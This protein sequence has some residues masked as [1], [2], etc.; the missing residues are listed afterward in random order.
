MVA[1]N[2]FTEIGIDTE[3]LASCQYQMS[4]GLNTTQ[5]CYFFPDVYISEIVLQ[6]S[7]KFDFGPPCCVLLV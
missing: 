7:F 3:N 1:L 6:S 4:I 2:D 5:L